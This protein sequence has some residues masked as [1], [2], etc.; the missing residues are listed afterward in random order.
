MVGDSVLVTF[1]N[2]KV[3]LLRPA[4][5]YAFA[6]DPAVLSRLVNTDDPPK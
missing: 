2:G 1:S 4:I 3:A 5:L 6:V